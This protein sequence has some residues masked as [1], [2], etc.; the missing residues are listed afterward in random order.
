MLIVVTGCEGSATTRMT[1]LLGM[2]SGVSV[3]L[4]KPHHSLASTWP[5][6]ALYRDPQAQDAARRV[7]RE[8]RLLWGCRWP[9]RLVPDSAVEIAN[10]TSEKWSTNEWPFESL[11]NRSDD[12]FGGTA[13]R[14]RADDAACA[15]VPRFTEPPARRSTDHRGG[16]ASR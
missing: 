14:R 2:L 15:P 5:S 12:L 6:R 13:L 4:L 10:F 11:A 3:A 8:T 1:S 16:S 7:E 9:P